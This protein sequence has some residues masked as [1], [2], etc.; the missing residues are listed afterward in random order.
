MDFAGLLF[1][2][3]YF[4][5]WLQIAN[6]SQ[7]EV[8]CA[9]DFVVI[10]HRF[11]SLLNNNYY[12]WTNQKRIFTNVFLSNS[13]S[14][15]FSSYRSECITTLQELPHHTPHPC[16]NK[17]NWSFAMRLISSL[18]SQSFIWQG[19]HLQQQQSPPWNAILVNI[20]SITLPYNDTILYTS[21]FRP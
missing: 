13:N 6:I 11:F 10:T 12:K 8:L 7:L 16:S 9:P 5:F 17:Y 3:F 2:S 19:K 21:A 20:N 18:H 4:T 14:S 1:T 15:Y